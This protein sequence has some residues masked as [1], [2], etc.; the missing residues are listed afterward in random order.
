MKLNP[1]KKTAIAVMIIGDY[2]TAVLA[3]L[4]F[5]F[6][7]Q[8]LLHETLPEIYPS[9]QSFTV[10]D[11]FITFLLIPVSW[12]LLY[13]LS[14]TYFDLYRK[15]R[16][17]EIYRS[18]I[19]TIIGAL[20][21]G[22][23]S[24][25]NDTNS[26]SYFFEV[27]SWY[28]LM[29]AS[30][31]L[32]FRMLWLY[33]VKKDLI[34]EKVGYNTLIVG[35][36]G[37]ATKVYNEIKNNPIVLGNIIIGFINVDSDCEPLNIPGV[38]ELGT[39]KDLEEIIDKYSIEEVVVA[40]ESH[41]H[42]LLENILMRL[43]YR[44]V[45]VKV[46]PDLYDIISGSV[47]ISNVYA[48]VLISINP[49]LLPDWQK[50]CKRVMDVSLAV[51][52]LIFLSPVYLLAAIKV[53]LSSKGSII[54]KQERIG[55]FGHPFYIYKFRS[56]YVN[57]ENEGPLLSKDDDPRITPWGKVMRKWRIDELPQFINI[58]K[59]DM[60]LVG[61]RPERQFYIDKIT[62]THPHYKYLHRVKPGI[63]SWGMVQYGYAENIEQMIER[64]KYDLL[65]IENCSL[66]LDIKIM[67][68]TVKVIL[69]GRGK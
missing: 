23:I 21:L 42:Q 59:G 46:L 69:Q 36:N 33:K 49:E 53:K 61:P 19:V 63:T 55:L 64:M 12:L 26:F 57:A 34:N 6:Y 3:W 20:V 48:P 35:G 22:M 11:Y 65:Y 28:F 44:P 25:A 50:V 62:R 14:G 40:V 18:I 39:L 9:S 54:Y 16:L 51:I 5:W 29:H 2:L 66:A 32:I 58:L 38:P 27:T 7:R 67:I 1:I 15:S 13:Y 60:S 10:R 68:Y 56:M 52:A 30:F 43:S 47:R 24:F 8:K 17:H 4:F 37:K 31:L 45:I 41:E